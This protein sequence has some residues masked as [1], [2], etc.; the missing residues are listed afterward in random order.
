MYCYSIVNCSMTE[1]YKLMQR[2]NAS[3]QYSFTWKVFASWDFAITDP[4]TATAKQKQITI[5]LK[6]TIVEAKKKED[7]GLR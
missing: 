7:P 1:K 6:E 5:A 2:D 4:R 3:E